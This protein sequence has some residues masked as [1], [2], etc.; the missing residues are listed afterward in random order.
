MQLARAPRYQP[1]GHDMMLRRCAIAV[2]ASKQRFGSGPPDGCRILCD[3]GDR[4]LQE[5]G[6][7]D[8]V[9]SD[10]GDLLMQTEISECAKRSD[11]DQVLGG[12]QGGRWIGSF[13][14]LGH[15]GRRVLYTANVEPYAPRV[16]VYVLRR[17][18]GNIPLIPFSGGG[19]GM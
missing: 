18:L 10:E 12:K 8:L 2:E 11:G 9:E 3:D 5:I 15:C 13:K 4:R 14:H 17:K 1:R 7:Q 19:D 6:K 16:Q